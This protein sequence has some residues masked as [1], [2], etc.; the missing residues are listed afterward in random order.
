LS[1][2]VTKKPLINLVWYGLLVVLGG[3]GVAAWQRLR[4]SRAVEAARG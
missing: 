4:E 3:G 1:I 2:D